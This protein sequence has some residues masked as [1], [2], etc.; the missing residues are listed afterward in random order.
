M[1]STSNRCSTTY[2]GTDLLYYRGNINFDD[3]SRKRLSSYPQCA[4]LLSSFFLFAFTFIDLAVYGL[5]LKKK[6]YQARVYFLFSVWHMGLTAR[7]ELQDISASSAALRGCPAISFSLT[8]QTAELHKFQQN[9]TTPQLY[10]Q[11]ES[12]ILLFGCVCQMI[13]TQHKYMFL[14]VINILQTI[15]QILYKAYIKTSCV[16]IA[17]SNYC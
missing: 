11:D 1:W 2:R 17:V 8:W 15:W 3:S 10:L 7:R 14:I 13:L 5:A 9:H 4:A 6:K 16:F 12:A